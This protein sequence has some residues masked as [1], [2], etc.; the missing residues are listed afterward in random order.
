LAESRKV[1]INQIRA[2]FSVICFRVYRA[3]LC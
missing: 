2:G 3:T 1:H